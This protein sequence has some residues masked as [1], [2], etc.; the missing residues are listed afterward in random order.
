VKTTI[1]FD[2]RII[3]R[4]ILPEWCERI[5]RSPA[6]MERQGNGYYRYWGY[7]E[8]AGTYL[9]VVLL[10]D[11]ETFETVHFDRNFMKRRRP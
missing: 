9:R 6:H 1:H 7:I 4:N 2:K 10:G 3:E 5:V 8:E 11:N